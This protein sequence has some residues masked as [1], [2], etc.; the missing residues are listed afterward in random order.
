MAQRPLLIFPRPVDDTRRRPPGGGGSIHR[1]SPAEQKERLDSKF[2][3]IAES[4]QLIQTTVQGIEPEQV[5]VLETVG[6][7]VEG[8]AIATAKVPGLEWLAEM[9]LD[10]VAPIGGFQDA[11]DPDKKLTCRLYAVMSNQRAMQRLL[12][13]WD[14][15]CATPD[16]TG[17]R[18]FGALQEGLRSPEGYPPLEPS[19]PS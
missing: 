16:K 11:K 15:W 13:L 18:G 3:N 5:I 10:D 9:D 4:F 2:R 7:A 1:P 12:S 17:A 19:R 8:L 14:Q 6:D